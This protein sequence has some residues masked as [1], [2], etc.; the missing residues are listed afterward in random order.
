MSHRSIYQQFDYLFSGC[1][2]YFPGWNSALRKALDL[3]RICFFGRGADKFA[4][5]DSVDRFAGLPV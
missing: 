3:S 4:Y 2:R 5:V 1:F